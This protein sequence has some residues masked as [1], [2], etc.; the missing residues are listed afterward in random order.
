MKRA[1]GTEL[2]ALLELYAEV[3][4]LYAGASC[5]AS[6][7]CC[8]FGITGREPQVTALEATLVK[9]A[10]ARRGGLPSEKRRA[11]PLADAS[12]ASKE[13]ICPLLD[14]N[15]R[16][17]IYADRPLGCRTFYCQRADV[18]SP[19]SRRELQDVVRRLQDLAARFAPDGDKP[20]ALTRVLS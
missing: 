13:R 6:S 3:D 15:A 16:C 12:D 5:P 18:P 19:P 1:G 9:R 14:Q 20:R 7:E 4:A 10:I 2:A 17:S 11:L 8:R